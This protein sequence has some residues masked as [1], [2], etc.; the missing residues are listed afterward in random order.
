MLLWKGWSILSKKSGSG[1]VE[2]EELP[3]GAASTG[4]AWNCPAVESHR[5]GVQVRS[6]P[7]LR[8]ATND[9]ARLSILPCRVE[10]DKRGAREYKIR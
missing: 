1:G 9:A 5:C 8:V 3:S 4:G 10:G 7:N 6:R 2:A